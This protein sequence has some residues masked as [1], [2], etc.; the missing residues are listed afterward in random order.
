MNALSRANQHFAMLGCELTQKASR[1]VAIS[2]GLARSGVDCDE[3]FVAVGLRNVNSLMS[4]LIDK[5]DLDF[6]QVDREIEGHG[7]AEEEDVI[8]VAERESS[9]S[10]E[11]D[12]GANRGGWARCGE[13]G[14]YNCAA[15]HATKCAE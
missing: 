7:A 2:L 6:D 13:R 5:Y 8:R 11:R 12:H 14:A 3:T 1:A 15:R 10:F 9:A 4:L